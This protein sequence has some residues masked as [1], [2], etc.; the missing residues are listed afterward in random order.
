MG[1]QVVLPTPTSRRCGPRRRPDDRT[2]SGTSPARR[3]SAPRSR[4]GRADGRTTPTSCR[5][6][7]IRP[8]RAD[9]EGAP[10][11][12]RRCSRSARSSRSPR[13]PRRRSSRGR[14]PRRRSGPAGTRSARSTRP[15]TRRTRCSTP[16]TRSNSARWSWSWAGWRP[17]KSPA[18]A[19]SPSRRCPTSTA[20]GSSTPPQYTET[21][22][23]FHDYLF[24][25]T[26]NEHLPQAYQALGV[27]G[28]DERGRCARHVVPSAVHPG[29]PGHRRRLRRRRPRPRRGS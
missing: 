6:W 1:G 23:A 3:C 10:W 21:N 19:C 17:S 7:P 14:R 12:G 5:R 24:T 27:K 29:P 28:T 11:P 13:A 16:G 18:T 8:R 2:G 4:R 22:A 9:Q 25:L 26:G 15:S 20:T